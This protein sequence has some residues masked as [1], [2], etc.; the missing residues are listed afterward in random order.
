MGCRREMRVYKSNSAGRGNGFRASSLV[1]GIVVATIFAVLPQQS[2]AQQ[3]DYDLTVRGVGIDFV[4]DFIF[5]AIH[6]DALYRTAGR[7]RQFKVSRAII[8][9]DLSH[10]SGVGGLFEY[11]MM[12]DEPKRDDSNEGYRDYYKNLG[13]DLYYY[14]DSGLRNAYFR[15]RRDSG[16]VTHE[17]RVGRMENVHGFDVDETPFWG[18][19]DSP[20]LLFLDKGLLTGLSYSGFWKRLRFDTFWFMGQDRPDRGYNYYLRGQTDPQVKGNSWP[21]IEARLSYDTTPAAGLDVNAFISGHRDKTGSAPGALYSGK[22]N[23]NRA[24]IGLKATWNRAPLVDRLHFLGEYAWHEMGLTEEGVQGNAS[25]GQ[26]F[27]IE[28]YGYFVTLGFGVGRYDLYYTFEELDRADAQVWDLIANFDENHP[29]MD[30]KERSHIV[31]LIVAFNEIFGMGIAYRK[32][33]NPFP[34]LSAI[35][36]DMGDDKILIYL[37]GRF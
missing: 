10:P 21:G 2:P 15:Y 27:D 7:E 8:G 11:N 14:G 1:S 16:H 33:E 36:P 18:R 34:E 6:D 9:A 19:I 12:V 23:D 32:V 25:P 13:T 24:A 17:F 31:Q 35:D 28:R 22:H 26:S 3:R 5:S 37:R 29:A 20:H 4:G 30:E